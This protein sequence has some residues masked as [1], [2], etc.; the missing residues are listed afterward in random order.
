MDVA[1]IADE[2]TVLGFNLVGV[3][4]GIVFSKERLKNDLISVKD[5]KILIV[6]EDVAKMIRE[7]NLEVQPVLAEIPDKSGSTGHA[8]NEI[9]RLFESAIGVTLKEED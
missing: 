3:K 2:D 9:S 5:A 4:K 7:Q 1:I 8:L 6:T